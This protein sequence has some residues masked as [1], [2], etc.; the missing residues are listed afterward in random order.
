MELKI[1]LAQIAPEYGNIQDN[2]A[3][4]MTF[5]RQAI[6]AGAGLIVFPELS[7]TGDAT[8]PE[9]RDVSLDIAS[10]SLAEII[11]ASRHIDIALG[12]I[13][14][15]AT[16]LYNRYN[17]GFYLSDG[18]LIHRHRKLF[19]VNYASFEEAKHYVPGNNLQAFDTRFGRTCMLVCND[20][21][22]AASPYIAALDGTELLLVLAN[23][24]R[25]TL[26]TTLDIPATWEHMNRAYSSM[27]GFYTVFVNRAG[28]R[29]TVYGEF[30]YWGGSEIIGPGG[31][32]IVKAPYDA[33]ALV[34]ADIDTGS[35]AR[36]RFNAPI[37][38]DARLW[39]FQQELDR[40]AT[41]RTEDVLL[42]DHDAQAGAAAD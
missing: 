35:V 32:I 37:L 19:L 8:D 38:R 13:E 36:Q 23:S 10:G 40:L 27:M 14:R 15:S 18:A 17:T 24:A 11:E 34:F 25:D 9:Y 7:L 5:I 26:G 42:D 4:H 22:H 16:N 33:E 3:K 20:V 6:D 29:H 31:K 2:L 28:T 41:Q 39:I 12:L 30:P 21:W 1:A